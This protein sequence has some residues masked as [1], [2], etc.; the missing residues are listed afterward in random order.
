MASQYWIDRNITDVEGMLLHLH[1]HCIDENW[2]IF[3]WHPEMK[4]YSDNYMDKTSDGWVIKYKR[5]Y[6]CSFTEK[7]LVN[8]NGKYVPMNMGTIFTLGQ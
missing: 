5:S 2:Y 6:S 8:W 7:E 3:P 4:D 1:K